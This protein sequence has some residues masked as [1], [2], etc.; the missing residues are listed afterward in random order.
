MSAAGVGC[1]RGSVSRILNISPEDKLTRAE[2]FVTVG[3]EHRI[4]AVSDGAVLREAGLSDAQIEELAGERTLQAVGQKVP[5]QHTTQTAQ[6]KKGKTGLFCE[7]YSDFTLPLAAA[8][9]SRDTTPRVFL[10]LLWRCCSKPDRDRCYYAV[11]GARDGGRQSS[12][13]AC[14]RQPVARHR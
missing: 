3:L 5:G 9:V 12:A 1:I 13:S 11:L 10:S 2:L 14:R 6:T 4:T 8:E 7:F